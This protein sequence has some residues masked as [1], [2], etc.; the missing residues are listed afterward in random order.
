MKSAQFEL[1]H[2]KR[3]PPSGGIH[4]DCKVMQMNQIHVR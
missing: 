4:V 2:Q 1:K 3:Y